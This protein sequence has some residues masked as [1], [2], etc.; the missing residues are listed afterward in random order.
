MTDPLLRFREEFPILARSTYLVSNSLG[1]MPRATRERL[2][3][4]ADAWD[5]LG[6]RA[7]AK[8]WWDMPVR[9]GDEIA[10][11]LGAGPGEVAMVPNVT[12]ATA[13]IVTSLD[14]APT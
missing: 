11:L 13:A 5:T 7:W 8:G 14:Y 9:V 10:P 12:A 2:N 6:V 4:Y 1:A 3:E